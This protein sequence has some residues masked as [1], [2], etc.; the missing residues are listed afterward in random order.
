MELKQGENRG[1]EF[2]ITQDTP[3]GEKPINL[4]PYN[5][6]VEIREQPYQ[7][8]PT[9][10]TKDISTT[11]SLDGIITKPLQGKFTMNFY[12]ADFQGLP[13]D[14][15]YISIYLVELDNEGNIITSQCISGV[16]NDS[17]IIRF[18]KC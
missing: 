4:T 7:E 15:Y 10:I 12:A 11:D 8:V 5:I 18:C 1:F 3:Q 6:K 2:T 17:A 16:G 9:I 13:P 14:E